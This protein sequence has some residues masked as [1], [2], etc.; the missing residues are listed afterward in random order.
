MDSNTPLWPDSLSLPLAKPHQSVAPQN[1]KTVMD[2]GR[3][4]N[5]RILDTPLKILEVQWNFTADHFAV[6]KT[7]F[8]EQLE[9][10]SLAFGI[11]IFG[12]EEEMAFADSTYTFSRSDNLFTVVAVLEYASTELPAVTLVIVIEEV[13]A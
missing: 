11:E 12:V 9:N 10:G 2:S 3:V 5:R 1:L 6:F 8:E 4:R 13:A 7:F